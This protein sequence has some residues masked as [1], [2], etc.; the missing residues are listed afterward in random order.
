MV[1]AQRSETVRSSSGISRIKERHDLGR[2]IRRA[3][4]C[5]VDVGN[6]H[7]AAREVGARGIDHGALDERVWSA[8]LAHKGGNCD[9][10]ISPGRP[11]KVNFDSPDPHHEWQ[12][13]QGRQIPADGVTQPLH[14]MINEVGRVPPGAH[15][16]V[17]IDLGELDPVRGPEYQRCLLTL[18]FATNRPAFSPQTSR[19]ESPPGLPQRSPASTPVYPAPPPSFPAGRSSTR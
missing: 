12:R 18:S 14:P 17:G 3:I 1:P 13:P 7:E 16:I 11:Q 6:G 10:L 2:P 8:E 4:R 15:M 5:L 9:L 19:T